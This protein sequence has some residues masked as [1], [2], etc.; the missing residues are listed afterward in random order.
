MARNAGIEGDVTNKS[1]RVTSITR[2]L[3]ARV[4]PEV[5]AQITG[6]RNLKT[7]SR[8]DKIAILKAK[9]AQNLLRDAYDPVTNEMHDFDYHYN[10]VMQEYHRSQVGCTQV[11]LDDLNMEAPDETEEFD[12]LDDPNDPI[13][14]SDD[15]NDNL[16]RGDE[17]DAAHVIDTIVSSHSGNTLSRHSPSV[18]LPTV[19]DYKGSTI[20]NPDSSKFPRPFTN[21][22]TTTR[23]RNEGMLSGTATT[24]PCR[25]PDFTGPFHSSGFASSA[26]SRPRPII[27]DSFSTR[28]SN[29]HANFGQVFTD[30]GRINYL[31]ANVAT[32][33]GAM[34]GG[35]NGRGRVGGNHGNFFPNHTALIRGGGGNVGLIRGGYNRGRGFDGARRGLC[36]ANPPSGRGYSRDGPGNIGSSFGRRSNLVQNQRG[37]V[38]SGPA[39]N[40]N[41]TATY[42]PMIRPQVDIPLDVIPGNFAFSALG[43]IRA[44]TTD[45]LISLSQSIDW[46]SM[47][48]DGDSD[49]V[50][51]HVSGVARVAVDQTAIGSAPNPAPNNHV[52][53]PLEAPS[54][55]NVTTSIPS[56]SIEYDFRAPLLVGAVGASTISA[57]ISSTA[58]ESGF[59]V[60]SSTE[61]ENIPLALVPLATNKVSQAGQSIDPVHD[62]ANRQF[63]ISRNPLATLVNGSF[64]KGVFNISVNYNNNVYKKSKKKDR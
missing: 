34:D 3:A 22:A 52:A 14:F 37:S 19:G 49:Q 12:G 6:H 33:R 7:L 4:P 29:M 63:D 51:D 38:D 42:T 62:D 59:E 9:A 40:R 55:A 23:Q 8:Y 53:I 50:V 56:A 64:H 43:Q 45:D 44:E 41:I 47:E 21:S 28:P 57:S 54:E 25:I 10:L 61:K 32:G 13:A 1:G 58:I 48:I 11:E 30:V 16:A 15:C 17:S 18:P 27:M 5:I 2:M 36:P 31:G 24:Q 39:M 35:N 60:A 20:H 46:G 26:P